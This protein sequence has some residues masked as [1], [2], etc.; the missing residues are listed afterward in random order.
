M[1]PRVSDHALLRYLERA[2]GFDVE[3][4]RQEIA[5]ACADAAKAGAVSVY[6]GP[7]KF[8]LS[9]CRRFVTT[10]AP[11]S[12]GANHTTRERLASK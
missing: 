7:V 4:L 3:G 10:S 8:Y 6:H 12:H 11:R 9:P 1:L 5:K 2:G